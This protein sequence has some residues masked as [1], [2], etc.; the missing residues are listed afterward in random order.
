MRGQQAVGRDVA[1]GDAAEGGP[2]A[3][4]EGGAVGLRDEGELALHVVG[5]GDGDGDGD[6]GGLYAGR[7]LCRPGGFGGWGLG[8]ALLLALLAGGSH[9]VERDNPRVAVLG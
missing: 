3:L 7:L 9:V 4:L 8:R 2:D 6:R 5:R 1:P